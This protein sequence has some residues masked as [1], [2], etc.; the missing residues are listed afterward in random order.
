MSAVAFDVEIE[1]VTPPDTAEF[2]QSMLIVESVLEPSNVCAVAELDA[3]NDLVSVF[4]AA[5]S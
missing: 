3:S 1:L 4:A 5:N 2:D